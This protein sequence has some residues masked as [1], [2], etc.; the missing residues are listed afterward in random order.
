M[1]QSKLPINY[2]PK[3]LEKK[4]YN[5]WEKESFFK[6]KHGKQKET[7]CIIMPPPNVTGRLHAGHALDATT[8]DVL[9]RFKRMKGFETLYIP[10]IDHAGIATQ[11]VVEKI[12]FKKEDKHLYNMKREDFLK[13]VWDWKKEYGD[14]INTQLRAMGVSADW[15]YSLFTMDTEANQSVRKAFV[16]LYNEKI[17]YQSNYIVNWDT[18]LK[19]AISDAEVEHIETKGTFYTLLYNIKDSSQKIEIATTRPE[20]LFGD[21]A[22]CVHPEDPRFQNIIGK[23][24]ITPLNNR[25]IPIIVDTYVN[26]E[27]GTGC[28]KVTPGHDFNDFEIGIRHKLPI[29]NILNKDGTLNHE[30]LEWEGLPVLKARTKI[31]NRLNELNI[32]K[33]KKEH[34]HSVGYGE[35]SKKIIEP[36]VSKQWFVNVQYMAKDA[37]HAV[38]KNHMK[39]FPK[40]WENTYFSWL[41]KP[42]DWCISRQLWWGHQ[43]PVY[44]C[45]QCNHQWASELEPS[46][47]SKCSQT[48]FYQDPDVLDTWFSSGLWPL[49]TL[50][51]PNQER[52]KAKGFHK[53]YPSN[54]LITGH[55]IIFFWVARM[56]MMGIK[57]I[58]EI[59]F[60]HVY[61]H[62]IIRDKQGQKMSKSLNNGIDPLKIIEEYGTDA[63][64]FT[65]AANSGYNFNLNLDPEKISGY[66]NFINKVWNAF[67]FVQPY[68]KNANNK[69]PN[70]KDLSTQERWIISELNGLTQKMNSSFEIYRYDN[71]CSEIY[72]FVYE[73]FCSWF[74]E[75]SKPIINNKNKDLVT[76]RSTVLKYLFKKIISLLHPITPVFNGGNLELPK[77]KK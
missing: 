13:K 28:L 57:F 61:I 37:L 55:D 49:S 6:P 70:T 20:T 56:M 7:F 3:D 33:E 60:H 16:Q 45:N 75:F 38:E 73:K 50:G 32:L 17:I 1:A 41:R 46:Q 24:A 68:L 29:I 71:A 10:G 54:V 9:I 21:T 51:W 43:I 22:I 12:I 18:E 19:S 47:C 31:V 8:Q 36:M 63:L 69:L 27:K 64:R 52:M 34:L 25:E 72:V 23:T 58:N 14:I 4:W 35:R 67:R 66:R 59:P 39:F 74:I 62:A 2:N 30:G 65:L 15:D 40:Q 44:Y 77:R 53:F 48:D 5:F 11:N 76:Q 42:K 26:R